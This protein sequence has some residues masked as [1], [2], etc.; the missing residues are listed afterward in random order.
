MSKENAFPAVS[1]PAHWHPL[2][3]IVHVVAA[4]PS[5]GDETLN[6]MTSTVAT[7]AFAIFP[8]LGEQIMGGVGGW[9]GGVGVGVGG[10]RLV[11]GWG[12]ELI[13]S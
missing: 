5:A 3:L 7:S 9:W 8:M 11:G 10:L 4:R 6:Q 12:G 1:V 13:H 2:A